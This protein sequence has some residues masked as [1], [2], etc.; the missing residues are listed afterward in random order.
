MQFLFLFAALLAFAHLGS[1]LLAS[2]S[3]N[4]TTIMATAA[5]SRA[6]AGFTF[7]AS[8]I[9]TILPTFTLNIAVEMLPPRNSNNNNN[10]SSPAKIEEKTAGWSIS[11]TTTMICFDL[12]VG[13]L[14]LVCWWRGCFWWM[15]GESERRR[16]E[17]VVGMEG[18]MRR[19][20]LW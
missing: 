9:T 19:L 7:P 18:E 16:V 2:A 4:T 11:A 5:K 3:L 13:I 6:M 8:T 14:F 20:G 1:A 17:R 12:F 15:K 10:I